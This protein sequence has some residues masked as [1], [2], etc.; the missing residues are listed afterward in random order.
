MPTHP[1]LVVATMETQLYWMKAHPAEVYRLV[2]GH[3]NIPVNIFDVTLF[4]DPNST[5]GD[6]LINVSLG[7]SQ[8]GEL[9][10]TAAL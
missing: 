3:I 9:P 4:P 10:F 5:P 1:E 7:F 6:V 2:A 8:V